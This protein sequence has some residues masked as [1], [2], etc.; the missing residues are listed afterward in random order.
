MIGIIGASGKIG[1]ECSQLLS[2]NSIPIKRGVRKKKEGLKN[3]DYLLL[4]DNRDSC[5]E[6]VKG[7]DCIINCSS[8]IKN[9]DHIVDAVEAHAAFFVDIHSYEKQTLEQF[10]K[11]P[12]IYGAGTSPGLTEALLMLTTKMFDKAISVNVYYTSFERFSVSAAKEYLEYIKS[13][14][15]TPMAAYK[16]GQLHANNEVKKIGVLSMMYGN[17]VIATP[18]IDNRIIRTCQKFDIPS[19]E[20]YFCVHSG[21]TYRKILDLSRRDFNQNELE[22]LVRISEK[23]IGA[24][25]KCSILV[26]MI[27]YKNNQ[28]L[29]CCVVLKSVSPTRL[30]ALILSAVSIL[31]NKLCFHKGHYDLSSA[32]D[33]DKLLNIMRKLD[34][35]LFL[36]VYYNTKLDDLQLI[37][38]EI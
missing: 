38:G 29:S 5:F 28:F 20:Y 13:N 31:S 1:K 19:A 2:K 4:L 34:P 12:L 10:N 22:D 3:D 32:V 21:P 37:E 7:C 26:E 6:F 16:N 15:F 17:N 25:T 8:R 18:Y 30:T 24:L 27:G 9:L 14:A 23:E 36:E 35:S 11:I 33:I